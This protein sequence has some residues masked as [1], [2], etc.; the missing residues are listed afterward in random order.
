MPT[1]DISPQWDAAACLD[2]LGAALF[3]R[4]VE[5]ERAAE[6]HLAGAKGDHW[7]RAQIAAEARGASD[8]MVWAG[9]LATRG[10]EQ[11]RAGHGPS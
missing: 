4:A 9:R 3:D 10:A 6:G 2:A 8:A 5:I 7:R 11:L 1:N